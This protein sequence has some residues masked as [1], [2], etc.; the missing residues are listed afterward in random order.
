MQIT[1]KPLSVVTDITTLIQDN[2]DT[3][4]ERD[5]KNES[6]LALFK[7]GFEVSEPQGAR[8][9]TSQMLY[10]ALWRILNKT[11]CLDFTANGTGRPEYIEDLVTFGI[12]TIAQ[13]SEYL[14]IMRTKQGVWWNGY[15]FGDGYYMMGT[16][17]D[18]NIPIIYSI[19]PN[20]NLYVDQYATA[21]RTTKGRSATQVLA[22]FS[23]DPQ[24]GYQMFPQLKKEDVCGQIPRELNQ[25]ANIETGRSNNQTW[26]IQSNLLELGYY[27]DIR[28]PKKPRFAIVA[29]S[30]TK[31]VRE[32]KGKEY[33]FWKDGKPY[34]PVGQWSCIPAAQGF[35]N[36]GIGDL[37]YRIAICSRRLMNMAYGHAEDSTYPL[38]LV[39]VANGQA[40]KFF[41]SLQEAM[42]G[43]A[44]GK[45]PIVPLEYDPAVPGANRVGA[46]SLIT[47]ASL[48]EFQNLYEIFNKEIRRLG[49][50]LDDI[51]KGP[52][53]TATQIIAEEENS[54]A[55]V[56]QIQE[57]NA[58]DFQFSLEVMLDL[59]KKFVKK[60]NK[61]LLD[62]P[63][64]LT[65][66]GQEIKAD[67][68]T[69]G[70]M[71]DEVKKHNYFFRI[72]ARTGVIPSNIM[73][74]AQW[75][76]VLP[77]LPPGSPAHNNA[78]REL[79]T[80]NGIDVNLESLQSPAPP[81]P[82]GPGSAVP[83]NIMPTETDTLQINASAA[84]NPVPAF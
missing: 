8:K 38:T 24:Q 51:E 13:K 62:I 41:A 17:D 81:M 61:T 69:L 9:L 79:A 67:S 35:Y 68:F 56:K 47:N 64:N 82:G 71:A 36:Y 29:G 76:R 25:I 37:L 59:T 55:W 21:I 77:L 58:S 78:I 53:I 4:R 33:P 11:K 5:S 83:A 39:N 30:Q 43:R 12:S 80:L 44:I 84:K 18:E 70:A 2:F 46:Q 19:I 74:Q 50:N 14:D 27:Y 52:D 1:N 6:I 60:S 48:A 15:L 7:E 22:I 66:D 31:V 40:S 49:I 54:N 34:I 20:S 57:F 73:K 45:K 75:S 32:L 26:K 72:N 63:V 42:K 10:Q 16:H 23:M 65:V 28:N 3:K